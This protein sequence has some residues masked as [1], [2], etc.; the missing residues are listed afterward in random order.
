MCAL[1]FGAGLGIGL[2]CCFYLA[3]KYDESACNAE[4]AA[5]ALERMHRQGWDE[6][7][8]LEMYHFRRLNFR[9]TMQHPIVQ[10]FTPVPV[11]PKHLFQ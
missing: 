5:A 9:W 1:F 7:R 10:L 6:Q 8:N 2:G 11:P 4:N 3:S